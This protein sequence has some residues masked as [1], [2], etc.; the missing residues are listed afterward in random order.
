MKT[1]L[2][3]LQYCWEKEKV[4]AFYEQAAQSNIPLIYLGETVCSRRRQLKFSDYFALAQ[5]RRESGKH[6]PPGGGLGYPDSPG[7]D[8]ISYGYREGRRV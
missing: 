5:M 4:N 3:P 6:S 1:S 2:G 7:F 8:R